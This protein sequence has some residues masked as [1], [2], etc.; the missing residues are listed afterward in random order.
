MT[1]I[2]SESLETFESDI[3]AMGR[4]REPRAKRKASE[5]ASQQ[6][7]KQRA[8]SDGARSEGVNI[9]S[10]PQW[11]ARLSKGAAKLNMTKTEIIEAAVVAF[12]EAKGI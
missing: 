12:L 10:T 1:E 4:V 3:E 5:K 8:R 6:S 11:V 9:R 7:K 2:D